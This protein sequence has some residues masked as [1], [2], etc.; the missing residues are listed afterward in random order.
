VESG[1]GAPEGDLRARKKDAAM[2]SVTYRYSESNRLL[3]VLSL[4]LFAMFLYP[5]LMTVGTGLRWLEVPGTDW[6]K[7]Y[8][9]A[10]DVALFWLYFALAVTSGFLFAWALLWKS[11]TRNLLTLDDVGLTYVFMGR[12][13]RW[14][15]RVLESAEVTDRP[16]GQQAA[17]LIISGRFGWGARIGL[18][19]MN[20]LASA[21]RLAITLPDFYEAPIE[22]V[23]AG[24]N[25]HRGNALGIKRPPREAAPPSPLIQAAASGQ[26]ITFN[27]SKTYSRQQHIAGVALLAAVGLWTISVLLQT[28]TDDGWWSDPWSLEMAAD[29]LVSLAI[30]GGLIASVLIFRASA[31]ARNVLRLDPAGLTYMR[32]GQRYAWP[33]RD[34]SAFEHHRVAGGP[35]IGRRRAITFAAPGRDW[36]WRWLRWAYGLP[37]KPPAVVIQDMYDTPIDEIAPT[38]NAYRERALGGDAPTSEP[39]AAV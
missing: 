16:L 14:P 2:Q 19:F 17:K 29:L 34:V 6:I 13:R 27:M 4:L 33:W 1:D 23:V 26:P 25:D 18:L 31:P 35:L 10:E 20:G 32:Q 21:G 12:R 5:A 36:T 3:D 38:L 30:V 7:S 8:G 11:P 9:L 28:Y 15:W 24:I 39:S 37:A 22:D